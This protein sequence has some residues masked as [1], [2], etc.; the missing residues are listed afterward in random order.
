MKRNISKVYLSLLCFF[1]LL[2]CACTSR[3]R[4]GRMGTK[5]SIP[6]YITE[7]RQQLEYLVEHYW[8]AIDLRDST[9][10]TRRAELE[11]RFVDYFSLYSDLEPQPI[12]LLIAPLERTSDALLNE[13]LSYYY[14]YY[15]TSESPLA[16]DELYRYV[17]VWAIKSPR[18]A[19]EH[20]DVARELLVGLQR[21][22]VGHVA[23]DFVYAT[24][25]TEHRL[26]P[27]QEELLL[28]LFGTSQCP[29]CK[30]MERYVANTPVYQRLATSGRMRVL[31]VYLQ[32]EGDK[33]IFAPDSLRPEWM[34]RGL[35]KGDSIIGHRL[36]DIKSS[37]TVYLLGRGDTVL[38]RDPKPDKLTEYLTHYEKK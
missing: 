30:A 31:T 12:R 10:L 23:T 29:S 14:R 8:D 5:S 11:A 24:D 3:G 1:V 27:V 32:S 17:L 21:N 35:D 25:T 28:L 4:V 9:W 19:R 22:R 2:S 36:Y 20:Q 34:E 18:V 33:S 7:P 6:G 15:Y 37:P 16:D 38:L 26:L 13:V